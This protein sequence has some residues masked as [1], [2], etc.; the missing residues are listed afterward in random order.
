M[1]SNKN[2]EGEY[3]E[4]LKKQIKESFHFMIILMET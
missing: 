3:K 1:K 2:I 4:L